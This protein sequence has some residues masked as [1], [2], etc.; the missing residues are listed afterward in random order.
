[1]SHR[2]PTDGRLGVDYEPTALLVR[3]LPFLRAESAD[4]YADHAGALAL[5]KEIRLF[6]ERRCTHP[7]G[8]TFCNW[9]GFRAPQT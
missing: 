9:C 2:R 6:L 8:C 7:M 3:T 4:P 1:M 5:L